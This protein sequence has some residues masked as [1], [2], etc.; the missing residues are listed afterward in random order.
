[1]DFKVFLYQINRENSTK[2]TGIVEFAF[3]RIIKKLSAKYI[4]A[5]LKTQVLHIHLWSFT[6]FHETKLQKQILTMPSDSEELFI[7]S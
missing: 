1:M 5:F 3:G 2:S 7:L 4:G 6:I